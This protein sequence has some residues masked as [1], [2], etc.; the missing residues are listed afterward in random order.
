MPDWS[1]FQE[2][3]NLFQTVTIFLPIRKKMTVLWL[4]KHAQYH[5]NLERYSH[6]LFHSLISTLD[7]SLA[8]HISIGVVI[9]LSV[10]LLVCLSVCLSVGLWI[11]SL[12]W[13]EIRRGQCN[14]L[15][16]HLGFSPVSIH[17][18]ISPPPPK[19]NTRPPR[20]ST[21]HIRPQI[22]PI[23]PQIRPSRPQIKPFSPQI[24]L[25]D[26]RLSKGNIWSVIPVSLLFVMVK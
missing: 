23:R 21:R 3:L 13:A 18:S 5:G 24:C 25:S 6:H 7:A 4:V 11:C 12:F 16:F 20:A 17:L 10:Y 9:C 15:W 22:R 14:D 2:F 19:P 8:P 1:H 26:N